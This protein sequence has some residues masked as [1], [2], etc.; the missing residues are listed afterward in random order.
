MNA[1][2][3]NQSTLFTHKASPLGEQK[4][5]A[6][7]GKAKSNTS[8]ETHELMSASVENENN[9]KLNK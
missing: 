3:A 4:I 8:H 2:P 9:T 6:F 1:I 7:V 5:R